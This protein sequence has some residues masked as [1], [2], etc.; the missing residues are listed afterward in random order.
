MDLWNT[1]ETSCNWLELWLNR[2]AAKTN[3]N[4]LELRLNRAAAETSCDW[5]EL[6]LTRVAAE[7][8]YDWLELQLKRVPT[9]SSC[10]WNLLRLKQVAAETQATTDSSYGWPKLISPSDTWKWKTKYK[11][12]FYKI[13]HFPMRFCSSYLENQQTIVVSTDSSCSGWLRIATADSSY[14]WFALRRLIRDFRRL[15]WDL[16]LNWPP[17]EFW[18]WCPL[19]PFPRLS[20]WIVL[21][22]MVKAVEQHG[23]FSAAVWKK[24]TFVSFNN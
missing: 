7:T 2:A 18:P 15:I 6:W 12:L 24:K 16:R 17:P 8:S 10:S 5:L 13:Y 23:R 4:W 21:L 14:G 11:D 9:D 20:W 3:C 19:I 22:L 1:A